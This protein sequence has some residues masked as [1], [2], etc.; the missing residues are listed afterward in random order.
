[1]HFLGTTEAAA[2]VA[3]RKFFEVDFFEFHLQKK[4][5]EI[6][7]HSQ[8]FPAPGK[9]QQKLPSPR[10]RVKKIIGLRKLLEIMFDEV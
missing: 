2:A 9:N 7:C 1:M 5:K 8:S 10:P 4:S 6:L 3:A